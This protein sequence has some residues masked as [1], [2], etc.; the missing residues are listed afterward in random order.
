M[1]VIGIAG[2]TGLML[3]GFGIRDSITRIARTQF[4]EIFTYDAT[5]TLKSDKDY[6]KIKTMLSENNKISNIV[7]VNMQTGSL[8]F[9]DKTKDINIVVP[10][11]IEEI[12][13]CVNLYDIETNEIDE[14]TEDGI[15]ITDKLSDLLGVKKDDTVTLVD[16]NDKEYQF[17]VRNIVKNYVDNYVFISKPLYENTI[18]NYSKNMIMFQAE[19]MSIDEENE[20]SEKMLEIDSV[21]SVNFLRE[22]INNIEN[23]LNSLNYVVAVLIVASAIL[24]FVVL[25]NLSNINISERKREIA[26]LKV[27]GFYDNEVDS[28]INK[29]SIILTT[30]GIALGLF[31]GYHL[32]YFMVSTCEIEILRFIKHIEPISYLYATVITVV[33]TVLVNI[34]IH[35]HLKKVDMIESLKSI[36]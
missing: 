23:T 12:R 17:K 28:Y 14:L 6:E 36:E 25:Y 13:K 8:K 33:F 10:N 22:S 18:G 9:E 31:F 2:C 1:T 27:L 26:T 5:I 11:E 15:I 3:S 24:A 19:N 20:L 29:E 21:Y 16:S 32:S 30:I 35:F 4:G 7:D 34:I